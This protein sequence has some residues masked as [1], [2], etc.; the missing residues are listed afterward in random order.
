MDGAFC[1]DKTLDMAPDAASF[2]LFDSLCYDL[3]RYNPPLYSSR[4]GVP[5]GLSVILPV[6]ALLLSQ[7]VMVLG[8]A[9][10]EFDR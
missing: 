10:L 5:V 9:V 4:F 6:V 8:L 3:R 2:R 1:I 7:L